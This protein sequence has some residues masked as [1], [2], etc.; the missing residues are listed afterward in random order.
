VLGYA[1]PERRALLLV[2]RLQQIVGLIDQVWPA[3]LDGLVVERGGLERER[4]AAM[5]E[6]RAIG[7]ER[8]QAR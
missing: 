7:A 4:A 1:V 6:A 2:E 3:A 5:R 8:V